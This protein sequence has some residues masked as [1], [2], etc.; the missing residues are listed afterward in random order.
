MTGVHAV[1]YAPIGWEQVPLLFHD[2]TELHARQWCDILETDTAETLARYNGDYFCG[3]PAITR[4]RFG[5]GSVYY[6][7]AVG[8][9]PM[10][11]RIAGEAAAEAA[12]PVI[13]GLPPRVEIV[14]RTAGNTAAR[15]V[16]NNDDQPKTF[17]LD[18][19]TIELSPFEM[20]I[21][22]Q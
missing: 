17:T 10:Y 6:L 19:Q 11:D 5:R 4:N 9:Q 22:M 16:F 15:F 8:T 14:T 1:E 13:P 18:A 2:G 7:G 12:L 21:I 20:K 3:A